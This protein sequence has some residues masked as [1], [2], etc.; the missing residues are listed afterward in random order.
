MTIACAVW[1]HG[2]KDAVCAIVGSD[3]QIGARRFVDFP[4]K[5]EALRRGCGRIKRLEQN[6]I[7]AHFRYL[8]RL[9]EQYAIA[10]SHEILAFAE[11][12]GA[13]VIVTAAE[14]PGK[15]QF[16]KAFDRLTYLRNTKIQAL[17]EHGGHRIGIRS[18]RVDGENADTLSHDGSGKAHNPE[19]SA[20][21]NIGARFHDREN[22]KSLAVK[23]GS[24][25]RANAPDRERSASCTLGT[26]RL[27]VNGG[28]ESPAAGSAQ[29]Q[30]RNFPQGAEDDKKTKIKEKNNEKNEQ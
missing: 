2:K 10:I 7:Y 3:G 27:S 25:L 26:L 1:L 30:T 15:Q 4:E 17:T 22:Q 29:E 13:Q 12:N 8:K 24:P 14:K 28:Q 23:E 11:E 18:A 19:L 16:E 9:N 5:R 20:A 21:Y 6:A